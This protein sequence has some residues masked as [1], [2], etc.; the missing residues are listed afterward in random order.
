MILPAI[1]II[2]GK[3]VRLRQGDY[4]Q[5]TTYYDDPLVAAKQFEQAG[6]NWLHLVDL[7]GAKM[8]APQNISVLKRI[9]E[10]THLQVEYG[11]GIKSREAVQQVLEAG[12]ARVIIGSMA[13]SN[14]ALFKELLMEYGGDKIVLGADC[15]NG[16][17]STHGWLR[18]SELSVATLVEPLSD[19]L[20]VVIVTDIAR[21]GMLSGPNLTLYQDLL[22]QFPDITFVASGGVSSQDDIAQLEK[23]GIKQII[24]GKALYEGKIEL[25]KFKN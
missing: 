11:G 19:F 22:K 3:C 1:D 8:A 4:E 23:I 15:K 5:K 14:P 20:K 16:K 17:V 18:Q 9:V 24:V 25:R 2:G 21:D 6:C 7:D 12:A 10:N 13:V